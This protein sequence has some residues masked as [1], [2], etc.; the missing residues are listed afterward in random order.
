[1]R[2]DL[3]L[4]RV[5]PS[6]AAELARLERHCFSDPGPEDFILRRLLDPL[7]D[8]YAASALDGTLAGY[9]G[10]ITVL[11]EGYIQNVAV[12]PEYRREGVGTALVAR[13]L[14]H[15]R[16]AG[17]RFLTLEVRESNAAARALYEQAGFTA[18]GRRERYYTNPPEAAILMTRD[19]EVL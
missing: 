18:A 10:L 11:D 15:G 5:G 9:I 13:V 19:F 4:E 17:L 7:C 1:M 8:F 16:E 12:A 2:S 14:K 6:R 3:S